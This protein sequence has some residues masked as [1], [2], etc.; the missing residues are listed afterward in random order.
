MTVYEDSKGRQ[1]NLRC[2]ANGWA[3]VKTEPGEEPEYYGLPFL[4]FSDAESELNAMAKHRGWQK[5]EGYETQVW[6]Y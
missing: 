3:I 2:Q 6:N 5:V 4:S 1:Y